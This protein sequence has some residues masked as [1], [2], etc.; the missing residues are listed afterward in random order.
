[1]KNSIL[2]QALFLVVL[3]V[4]ITWP[5]EPA[6][7]QRGGHG[8]GGFHGGGGGFHGGGGG[9]GFH[10]GG[11]GWHGSA[12]HGGGIWHGGGWHGGYYRGGY[13]GY[14]RY[15]WGWG[16]GWGVGISFGWGGYWPG[17]SYGYGY[18]P[19]W[20]APY[21]P[22]YYYAAPTAYVGAAPASDPGYGAVPNN[23]APS[24]AEYH[25]P[26]AANRSNSVVLSNAAYRS[27]PPVRPEVKTVIRALQGM[28]P[29]ARQVQLSR[30]TNLSPEEV[31]LVRYLAD[32]P[33][34]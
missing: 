5:P 27:S 24:G 26:A 16:S 10:G 13:W 28:P 31:E 7:A 1:M 19:A 8:G 25:A 9:V 2:L 29:S 4:M 11:G 17:Y 30:Y 3:A 33:T 21:Y 32:V 6:Y 12:W 15:G 22:Y 18:A 34:S 14:P 20:P 23:S